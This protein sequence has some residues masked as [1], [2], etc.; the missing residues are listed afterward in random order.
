MECG[1][2]LWTGRQGIEEVGAVSVMERRT[3]PPHRLDESLGRPI[4]QV[5]S[6][7]HGA[8]H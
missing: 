8:P 1:T 6:G 4:V 2:A 5:A 3:S 7:H